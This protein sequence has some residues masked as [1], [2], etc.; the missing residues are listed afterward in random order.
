MNQTTR[1]R[2]LGV[3][4]RGIVVAALLCAA[5][6][7]FIAACAGRGQAVT[8]IKCYHYTVSIRGSAIQFDNISYLL[9]KRPDPHDENI[10]WKG[11]TTTPSSRTQNCV[12]VSVRLFPVGLLL[13]MTAFSI[14]ASD[15]YRE[16]HRAA[17]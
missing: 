9:R 7:V 3:T 13:S 16:S 11:P 17:L 8:L 5:G 12:V 14:L 4:L 15:R 2:E 1:L 10:I 6:L